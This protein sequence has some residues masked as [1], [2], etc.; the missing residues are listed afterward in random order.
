MRLNCIELKGR[1]ILCF[2]NTVNDRALGVMLN[3]V[4]ATRSYVVVCTSVSAKYN[5]SMQIDSDFGRNRKTRD[6]LERVT[7]IDAV[8][9]ASEKCRRKRRSVSRATTSELRLI[10]FAKWIFTFGHSH[11]RSVGN[12]SRSVLHLVTL[13]LKNP[14]FSIS[15]KKYVPRDVISWL[16]LC[17]VLVSRLE[18]R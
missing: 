13:F 14:S 11:D 2:T 10:W 12:F 18:K 9:K 5:N 1:S 3:C 17:F 7:A 4:W 15:G 6:R 8:A 16:W